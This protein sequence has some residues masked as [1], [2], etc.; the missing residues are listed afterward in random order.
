MLK[1]RTLTLLLGALGDHEAVDDFQQSNDNTKL[2]AAIRH[3]C[4]TLDASGD[5]TYDQFLNDF[6][7]DLE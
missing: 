7:T 4:T 1:D 3:L 5:I 6:N 2:I